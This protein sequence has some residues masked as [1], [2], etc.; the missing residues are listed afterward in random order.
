TTSDLTEL[1]KVEEDIFIPPAE[2]NFEEVEEV[3]SEAQTL[4]ACEALKDLELDPIFF[5]EASDKLDPQAKGVLDRLA[6]QM[7]SC[8][9]C[10]LIIQG[11]TD[12]KGGDEYNQILSVLRAYNVK[13]Y[14]VYEH[15]ISQSRITSGGAGEHQPLA[16]N[17]TDQGRQRNRRV[18][19]E[20]GF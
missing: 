5:E 12:A 6:E 19:F 11:H 18:D 7:A 4:G 14:L 9:D 10:R 3:A 13:Y 17:E 15:G 1:A 16:D 20:L 8:E 2:A